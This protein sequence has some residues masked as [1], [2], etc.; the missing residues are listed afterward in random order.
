[1]KDKM[2]KKQFDDTLEYLTKQ[3]FRFNKKYVFDKLYIHEEIGK[4]RYRF[5]K[6][7]E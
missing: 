3:K 2:T 4:D 7:I 1:M 6:V 5:I